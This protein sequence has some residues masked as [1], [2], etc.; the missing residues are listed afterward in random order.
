[1]RTPCQEN[2]ECPTL[3]VCEAGECV[4][5]GCETD[6]EC[7]N[8]VKANNQVFRTSSKAVCVDPS[9]LS[10]VSQSRDDLND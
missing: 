3:N 10:S 5:Y 8:I 1:C 2:S 7:V 9:M 6:S 4:Y